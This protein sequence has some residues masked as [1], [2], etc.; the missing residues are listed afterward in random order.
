MPHLRSL[1]LTTDTDKTLLTA[2]ALAATTLPAVL[3]PTITQVHLMILMAQ[4]VVIGVAVV[5]V[6]APSMEVAIE[7]PTL[8]PGVQAQAAALP[9]MIYPPGMSI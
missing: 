9:M 6:A 8:R 5:P 2:T 7:G 1:T 3:L 4:A